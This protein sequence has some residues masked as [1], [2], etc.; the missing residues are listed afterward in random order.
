MGKCGLLYICGHPGTGKTSSLNL[1]LNDYRY[2]GVYS[3]RDVIIYN[4]NAM[5]FSELVSFEQRLCEDILKDIVKDREKQ[6]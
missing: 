4:Y 6:F 3:D 5:R 2:E 1:I